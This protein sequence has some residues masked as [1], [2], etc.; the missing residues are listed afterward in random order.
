MPDGYA[1][2]RDY[3]EVGLRDVRKFLEI[4]GAE[5]IERRRYINFE[6]R[7]RKDPSTGRFA[8]DQNLFECFKMLALHGALHRIRLGFYGKRPVYSDHMRFL[9]YSRKVKAMNIEIVGEKEKA[10]IDPERMEML[11]ETMTMK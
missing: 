3:E 5:N 8:F 9:W 7:D 6:F 2:V 4:I 10:R 11:K 1:E